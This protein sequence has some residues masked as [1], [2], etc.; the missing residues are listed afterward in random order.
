M[1]PAAKSERPRTKHNLLN[2]KKSLNV[3]FLLL[4]LK[5]RLSEILQENVHAYNC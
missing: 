1:L 3:Y 5:S 2:A 4:N